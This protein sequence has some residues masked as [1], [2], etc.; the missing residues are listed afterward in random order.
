MPM[1]DS[2]IF[3]NGNCADAMHF[4]SEVLGTPLTALMKYG[5]SP[6]PNQCAPGS[7]DR[8]MHAS[9]LVDGR[10]LMASDVPAGQEKPVQGFA[11]SLFY[12][13]PDEARRIFDRLSQ[14]GSVMMPL[15]ETFWAQTF[16][17]FTDRFGT[18]WMVS[19]GSKMPPP[20]A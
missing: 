16:G 2:Y 4:Y 5:D 11:L 17:M 13:Q 6:E 8:I 12:D 19:G 1:L 20:A 15:A 14:G 10:N 7:A 9:M 3:F 18:P